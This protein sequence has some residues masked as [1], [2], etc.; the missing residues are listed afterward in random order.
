VAGICIG[1]AAVAIM[2]LALTTMPLG[3]VARVVMTIVFHG[4]S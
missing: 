2:H 3:R 1:H 4:R